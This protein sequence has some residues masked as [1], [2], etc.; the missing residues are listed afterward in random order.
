[1][2]PAE[3]DEDVLLTPRETPVSTLQKMGV[4]EL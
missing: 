1:L 3:G 4:I 2:Q